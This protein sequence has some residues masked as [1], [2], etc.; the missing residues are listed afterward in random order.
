M[1]TVNPV[2]SE[3]G[4]LLDFTFDNERPSGTITE[5]SDYYV[6]NN[7]IHNRYEEAYDE[8]VYLDDNYADLQIIEAY[9]DL[10]GGRQSYENL[11][12]WAYQNWDPSLVNRFDEAV[13]QQDC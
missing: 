9:H 7:E 8:E 1:V 5:D 6:A 12:A 10:A 4:T 11:T 2:V 13:D 3:D